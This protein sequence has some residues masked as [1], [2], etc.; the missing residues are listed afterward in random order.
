MPADF[1]E[2][3]VECIAN[4]LDVRQVDSRPNLRRR[5]KRGVRIGVVRR[6]RRH[7]ELVKRC[8]QEVQI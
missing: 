2:C 5:L 1:V 6:E 7:N 4:P 8:L 3:L